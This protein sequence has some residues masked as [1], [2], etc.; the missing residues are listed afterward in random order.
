LNRTVVLTLQPLTLPPPPAP[1]ILMVQ[2]KLPD[3]LVYVDGSPRGRTDRA[4]SVTLALEAR[5]L[6]VRVER[7]GYETPAA[8]QVKITVGAQQTLEFRL[9]PQNASLVLDGAPADLEVRVDGKPVGR[10]DGSPSYLFPAPVQSGDRTLSVGRGLLQGR[11]GSAARTLS[12]RFDP[13]Q[14]VRL[15]WKPE[16]APPPPSVTTPPVVKVPP[17][18]SEDIVER[19]WE[20]VRATSDPAQL[21]D[22]RKNHPNAH[23]AEAEPLLDRLAWS[24]TKKDSTESLHAYVHDFPSGAYATQAELQIADLVWKGVDRAKIEQ[25]R[26]FLEENPKGPHALEAQRIL[27]RVD[28]R[29]DARLDL[30]RKQVLDVLNSLDL[31]FEKKQEAQIKAIW[32]KTNREW[33]DSLRQAGQKISVKAQ[34][35]PQVQGD[36]ATV[37]CTLHTALPR[38]KD[39][40]AILSLRYGGGRWLIDGLNVVQ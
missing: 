25:V 2:T 28:A 36:T 27:D 1:L 5:D 12:E 39:Q 35:D 20:K 30:L 38:P 18:T 19:D 16:P 40:N 24:S 22:F 15:S 29:Q 6:S 4:G 33:L 10:T 32:P 14:S 3:V 9:T 34:E 37:R 8:K 7:N 31:A 26:K 17:I 11:Q 21:R 23:A 13:G